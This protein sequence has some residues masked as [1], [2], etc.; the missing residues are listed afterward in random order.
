M[1]NVRSLRKNFTQFLAYFSYMFVHFSFILL[2][3]IWLD[4]DFAD[5]F[6]L[7][8]FYKFDLCRNNYG[9]GVRLFVRDGISAS[10]LSD[11]TLM[12]DYIEILTVECLVNGVKFIVSLIYHSP[13]ASHVINN[14]FVEHLLSLLSQLKTKHLPLIVGGDLNLNLLNPYNLGYI[15]LFINGMFE[16]NLIPAI[17]IPTKVNVENLVTKYSIIDQFWVSSTI[18]IANACVIPSDLTDHFLAGLTINFGFHSLRDRPTHAYS[19]RPLSDAGK[20]AFR[21]FLSNI[22]VSF[23]GNHNLN[24]TSYMNDM[25]GSYN[26]AFP[27]K[28]IQKKPPNYVPWISQRLKLCI[29]KKSKLYKLYMSG[30][31]SRLTYTSF[32]NRLTAVLRRAKRLYYVELFYNAG[33]ASK[34]IWHVI[35][36]IIVKKKG[37]ILECLEVNGTSLTGLPLVNYINRYFAS[38]ALTVTRGLIP[39]LVYPFSTPPV[40]NTCFFIPTTP[41]EVGRVIMNLKN[42]GS[43]VHDVPSVLIKENKDIFSVQLS[44]CYNNS[45]DESIYPDVLKVG[46]ITPA[47]KSGTKDAIDNYR[48]ISALPTI[49]KIYETLTLSRMMSFMSTFSIFSPAQ[50]GF[51]PGKSTTQ[52]IIKLLSYVNRAYHLKHY[53]VCFYLD[54]R[55]AFDTVNHDILFRK[56]SHYG[57]RGRGNDYL[58]SYFS[59]RKQRVCLD[60]HQSDFENINSGVPQGSTLGPLCF[61]LYINDF[62][63]AV[64]ENCVLFADDAAFIIDSSD[65]TDLFRRI[66]QLFN[67]I[68]RYLEYNCLVANGTKSKLMMFSS[69]GVGGLPDFVFSGQT[70]EWVNE[71]KYLGLILNNRLSYGKHISKVSLNISRISGMLTSVRDILPRCIL[72]KLYQ[73]LAVPHINLHLEI[74]GSA[75]IYLLNTLET[76][77]NNLLR[78]I[79]GIYRVNGIPTM[80]TREMYNTN[81]ILR[82]KSIYQLRLF[83]FLR[84]LLDGRIPELYDLLLRPYIAH[85][86]YGTRGGQFRHP[87]L[88]CEI[89][90]RFL[91]Y[92]LIIMYE[93]LPDHFFV[94]LLSPSL[95]SFRQ[96]LLNIQ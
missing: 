13:T 90:R 95:R 31:V 14:M 51:R 52:A 84:A 19:R 40:L 56:L 29:R 88:T 49:S 27:L 62:P 43:K 44:I 20:N 28:K 25:M 85:H 22:N 80:G 73:A 12:N 59:N 67:D 21:V 24:M 38:A 74:W 45:L 65:L 46:R 34:Q 66:Q 61:G 50:Y 30:R 2:T 16:L 57:F 81:R 55:K 71:Y 17:N 1:L 8:G 42:K 72:V 78:I 54:L 91:S 60:G 64:S 5:T 23:Q 6:V 9:G 63:N 11:F 37:H 82:L 94:N 36:S 96:Y 39:P 87:N 58:R 7:P 89:E 75:P 53:C 68:A 47:Y 15:H 48:P 86:N 70:I 69:R 92:Q 33:F 26:T 77:M 83:K 76:K 41:T 32:R 35:N 4:D 18:D 93:Q 79:F 10:V 3:E